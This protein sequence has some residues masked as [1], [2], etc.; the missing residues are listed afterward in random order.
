MEQ[1]ELNLL[2]NFEKDS[3][4]FHENINKLREGGFTDK[5]VAVKNSQPIA[6]GKD[7]DLVIEEIEAKH[8]N[9][10]Y[11]FIEFVHPKGKIIIL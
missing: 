7:I 11:V 8:Q 6:F 1:Q 2:E 3:R 5:F 10:A 4:W 9:P